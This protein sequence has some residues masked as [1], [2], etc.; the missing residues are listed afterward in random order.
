MEESLQDELGR[1]SPIIE[2][3]EL[4]DDDNKILNSFT[5]DLSLTR[6]KIDSDDSTQPASDKVPSLSNVLKS[7]VNT[8]PSSRQ[9]LN[10]TDLATKILQSTNEASKNPQNKQNTI[11][12]SVQSLLPNQ[13]PGSNR[14]VGSGSLDKRTRKTVSFASQNE[15][16]NSS[17]PDSQAT[18]QDTSTL[19][20]PEQHKKPLRFKERLKLNNQEKRFSSLQSSLVKPNKVS[21][22]FNDHTGEEPLESDVGDEFTEVQQNWKEENMKKKRS[23]Y[24]RMK[25]QNGMSTSE[26]LDVEPIIIDGP[27]SYKDNVSES[28]SEDEDEHEIQDDRKDGIISDF[29]TNYSS[30]TPV[31]SE[32]DALVR[33]YDQGLF[34]DHEVTNVVEELDDFEKLN[35]LLEERLKSEGEINAD[36]QEVS[37]AGVDDMSKLSEGLQKFDIMSEDIVENDPSLDFEPEEPSFF[38]YDD[39][40][41]NVLDRDIRLNYFRLKRKLFPQRNPEELE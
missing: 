30:F 34:D 28:K 29:K 38:E 9:N 1:T 37:N 39:F 23:L 11:E 27:S 22:T 20:Q 19:E 2:I 25:Y 24:S 18:G 17:V 4:I 14:N 21:D 5:R 7:I 33:A 26:T 41:K 32:L 31:D 3:I 6:T 16:K 13:D 10:N 40:Q 8:D 12:D 35:A 36:Y 15:E